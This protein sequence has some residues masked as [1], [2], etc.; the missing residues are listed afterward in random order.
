MYPETFFLSLKQK[1]KKNWT[2]AFCSAFCIG[3]LIHLFRLTNHL[4]TWDSVYNFYD[5]Q[6]KIELG[7]CFL[8]LSCGIGSYYDLQWV[9]GLLSLCYLS[10]T[11]ICLTEI[12][13]LEKRTSIFLICALTVSFPTVA[14]TFAYMYT[15]DGYFLAQLCAALAVLIT[16][17]CKKGFL[18][19]MIFLAFSYGSYQAYVSYAVMLILAWT[20]LQIL[21]GPKTMRELF[22][23]WLRFF[24]MGGLGTFLYFI[25]NKSLTWLQN[26]T[27]SEYNGISAMSL[28]DGQGFIAAVKNCII[29]FAYFFFGPLEQFNLYKLLNVCLFLL[30]FCLLVWQI[31]KNRLYQ[32]PASFLMLLFCF[33]CMP[34]ACSM[35]Y[36]LSPDVRYYMLMYAGFSLIYMLP[37]LVY[38]NIG[39]SSDMTD[40]FHLR[41]GSA[42]DT[43]QRPAI[44]GRKSCLLSWCCV[45]LTVLTV[46]NFALIDNIGYLY[47]VSSN[48]KTFQLVSRMTDRIEQLEDFPS[49]QKLCVIGHFNDYDT[50]ALN[51]PPA[52]AG[53]R[54]SYLISESAHFTA[55]MDTYFG[56]KLE[57]CTKEEKENIASTDALKKM[58]CWPSSSSVMQIGDIVV[59]KVAEL[60]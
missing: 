23:Q 29:D 11:C 59:V 35:I 19:G 9:T 55:M 33:A 14:S 56:L 7:R 24:L 4:L 57:P 25:C 31:W 45:L 46:F 10:L 48:E 21:F 43:H 50:I 5:P 27:T 44:P 16:L 1:M 20:I 36:F 38:D 51:L 53:I 41:Q 13:S 26:A 17:K 22:S 12:F 34:F 15:A 40:S 32:K 18:A 28:P 39:K 47:M 49:A 60:Q 42:D 37:V 52:M 3:L 8:T 54:D 6:N 58:A 2:F 30:L